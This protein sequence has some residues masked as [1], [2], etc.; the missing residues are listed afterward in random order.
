MNLFDGVKLV[1]LKSENLSH[2][3][4]KIRISLQGMVSTHNLKKLALILFCFGVILMVSGGILVNTSTTNKIENLGFTLIGLGG[5][6]CA[7]GI[8]FRLEYERR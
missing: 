1:E 7:L 4:Y 2:Q 3:Q 6:F 5:T 8:T